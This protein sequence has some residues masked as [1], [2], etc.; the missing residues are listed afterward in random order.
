MLFLIT[1]AASPWVPEPF[2]RLSLASYS[3]SQAGSFAFK[4][5]FRPWAV[6]EISPLSLRL[7]AMTSSVVTQTVIQL[8]R[9]S[10]TATGKAFVLKMNLLMRLCNLDNCIIRGATYGVYTNSASPTITNTAF[11][12]NSYGVYANAAS[13]PVID[14][15]DFSKHNTRAVQNQSQ[16]FNILAENCWWGDCTGPTHSGNPG[17]AGEEVTDAVDYDPFFCGPKNPIMG[18]VSLNGEIQAYDASLILQYV[19]ALISLDTLQKEVADVS[20]QMGITALDASLV[21]QY[22]VGL[23]D[24]FPAESTERTQ[25][26]LPVS[27]I[28]L[29]IPDMIAKPGDTISVNVT[30]ENVSN[31]LASDVFLQYD[32]DE[33]VY[34]DFIKDGYSSDMQ[35]LVTHDQSGFIQ[36]ILA[37][38]EYKQRDGNL[39]VL[40]F[41]IPQTSR[42]GSSAAISV[43]SFMAN[44]AD[45]T[46]LANSGLIQI[47]GIT[48]ED[49]INIDP[50]SLSYYPNPFGDHLNVTIHNEKDAS[51]DVSLWDMHGRQLT[52]ESLESVLGSQTVRLRT[53]DLTPG[54]YVLKIRFGDTVATHLVT[55]S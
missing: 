18:D 3:N 32:P 50:N 27:D 52:Q 55:R 5:A 34:V 9:V 42:P 20:G 29:S 4:K 8:R 35:Q 38:Y 1:S 14:S 7:T 51:V 24:A 16:A 49:V 10:P 30:L 48:V 44:E 12:A 41:V 39:G 33:L 17:G 28:R 47:P 22:L 54:S 23:L 21:L 37:G 31:L 11:Q 53:Q 13:N 2:F 36:L 46:E 25:G 40:R 45:L 6:R 43:S 19:A 26:V 15:C